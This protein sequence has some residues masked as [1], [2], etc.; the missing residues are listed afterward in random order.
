MF[1]AMKIQVV[2]FRVMTPCID[3]VGYQRF[4][5][6][7]CLHLHISV[8]QFYDLGKSALR[9]RQ[10]GPPKRRYPTTALNVVMTQKA[11]TSNDT[12]IYIFPVIAQSV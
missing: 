3:V 8:R 1:V 11:R 6:P 7:R 9:W 10:Y 4:R 12:Y 5:E 2:F